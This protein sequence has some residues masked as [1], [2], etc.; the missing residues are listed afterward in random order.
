MSNPERFEQPSSASSSKYD[1]YD[2]VE[3]RR[4][5][6]MGFFP[7]M[8]E[9]DLLEPP[10]DYNGESYRNLLMKYFPDVK[11]RTLL[12]SLRDY[13]FE[14]LVESIKNILSENGRQLLRGKSA[15]ER[16]EQSKHQMESKDN[17]CIVVIDSETE[18]EI[19][20]L[21][22]KW[23]VTIREK[24]KYIGYCTLHTIS[25]VLDFAQNPQK[26][27]GLIL[28]KEYQQS[29]R[30]GLT[31]K[32][33]ELLGENVLLKEGFYGTEDEG[34]SALGDTLGMIFAYGLEKEV[35]K[36]ILKSSREEIE[37][38]KPLKG[39]AILDIGSGRDG[40]FVRYLK[41]LGADAIGLDIQK[42]EM[43]DGVVFQGD[44]KRPDSLPEQI[45]DKKFDLVTSTMTYVPEVEGSGSPIHAMS[46][47]KE[48]GYGIFAPKLNSDIEE[49]G[50][51]EFI[52]LG[53]DKR[54]PLDRPIN[55]DN[56]L[57][58]DTLT[59][60]HHKEIE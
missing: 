58:C 30:E 22:K 41:K 12:E 24:E 13:D 46:F 42:P 52:D 55:N 19:H 16:Y 9:R 5:L 29:I 8:Q 48:G 56:T 28:K 18:Y 51:G 36:R 43:Q 17:K 38:G 33:R 4:Y 21:E 32:A 39:L 25:D 23:E 2:P 10:G 54:H 49:W 7:G 31:R 40:N 35:S 47:I 57:F 3:S 20:P 53:S 50:R 15:K 1:R 6:L 27:I 26:T 44:M 14:K 34:S 11:E 37:E 60:I 59:V 45:K